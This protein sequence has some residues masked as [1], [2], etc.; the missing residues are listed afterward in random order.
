M[1]Y[2]PQRPSVVARRKRAERIETIKAI[3]GAAVAIP[4]M[5]ALVWLA[6][7]ATI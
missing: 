1:N 3:A 6:Y 7:F 4:I 2:Q 5:W